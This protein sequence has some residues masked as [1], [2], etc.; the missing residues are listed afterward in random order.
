MWDAQIRQ[1]RGT[2]GL[3]TADFGPKTGQNQ[4]FDVTFSLIDGN[5]I[6][7]IQCV[8]QAHDCRK[9]LEKA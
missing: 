3:K 5:C 4:G 2:F 1:R 7:L 6:C 9:N 8:L